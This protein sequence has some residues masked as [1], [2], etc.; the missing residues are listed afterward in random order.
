MTEKGKIVV[1]GVVIKDQ[2]KYLLV[3]EKQANAYGLWNWPAGHVDEGE[4]LEQGAIRE[5]REEVGYEVELQGKIGSWPARSSDI[6]THAFRA[7]ITGGTFHWPEDEILTA[8]WFT[9]DEIRSMKD[10]L[11]SVWVLGAVE[12]IE[13]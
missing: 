6:I 10:Q 13:S 2:G 7:K 11:R 1:A 3:Q 12:I 9:A 5:A 4:T 8:V